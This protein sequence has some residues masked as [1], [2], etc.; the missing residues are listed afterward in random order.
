MATQYRTKS[1]DLVIRIPGSH[2]NSFK[3][4]VWNRLGKQAD[5]N[6]KLLEMFRS[7]TLSWQNTA[8]HCY[9]DIFELNRFLIDENTNQSYF[10]DLEKNNSHLHPKQNG[11]TNNT[12]CTFSQ[13]CQG[14]IKL[15]ILCRMSGLDKTGTKWDIS[16]TF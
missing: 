5:N 10:K 9:I 12:N 4:Q 7:G 13:I 2:I 8:V 11:D 14:K 6:H 1:L 16:G 3:F 15:F